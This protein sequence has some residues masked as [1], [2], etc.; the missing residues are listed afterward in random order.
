V[1]IQAGN[2]R[3]ERGSVT[4]IRTD[5]ETAETA[6]GPGR[7]PPAANFFSTRTC[8][9]GGRALVGSFRCQQSA[10]PWKC[11]GCGKRGKPKAGFPLF[12]RAPWKSRQ[13]RARFPHSHSSDDE[14]GWK[15]GKPKAGFPLSHYSRKPQHKPRARYRPRTSPLQPNDVYQFGNISY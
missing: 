8:R 10:E 3:Q 15:S 1:A 4:G 7:R 11:R 6:S 14:G 13:R 2:P 12:P 9:S 5:R